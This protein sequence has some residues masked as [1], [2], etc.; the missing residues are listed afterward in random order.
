M[1]VVRKISRIGAFV[2]VALVIVICGFRGA[3][4][5]REGRMPSEI[6]PA[7]GRFIQVSD[8]RIFLQEQGPVD[9]IPVMLIHGTGAWSGL[10]AETTSLLAAKG[11]RTVS[12]DLP[13]FGFSELSVSDDYSRAAQARRLSE[14]VE[15]L[16]GPPPIL[17]GHSYGGGPVAEF[18]LREPDKLRELVLVDAALGIGEVS[19]KPLPL[20]LRSQA[21]R[22]ALV[23]LTASN[24]LMTKRIL[25]AFIYRKERALPEYVAILSRPLAKRGYT[26][27]VA[28]WLPHLLS[29]DA[30]AASARED[31]WRKLELPVEILWGDK[32]TVTPLAQAE[33][34]AELLPRARL[35]VLPG[36]GHIPQVEA[37]VP[38]QD[39]L[40]RALGTARVADVCTEA[41]APLTECQS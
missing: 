2:F 29:V 31:P 38:F 13:P 15:A 41:M 28:K 40:I 26:P 18:A 36:V 30:D 35:T 16:G 39:A 8:A 20:P 4:E 17:V 3:A 9:G 33:H 24:P 25:S 5:L 10:W 1:E 27:T 22:E 12:V 32:D 11:Y 34:L 6:A 23:S 19:G 37:P 7:S 21:L 14:V